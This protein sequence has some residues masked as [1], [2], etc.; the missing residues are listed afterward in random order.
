MAVRIKGGGRG[1]RGEERGGG[2]FLFEDFAA[3]YYFIQ[4]GVPPCKSGSEFVSQ[5]ECYLLAMRQL[6]SPSVN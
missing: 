3:F 2:E 4:K 1:V 6:Y 5:C